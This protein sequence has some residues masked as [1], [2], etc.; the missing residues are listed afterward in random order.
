MGLGHNHIGCPVVSVTNVMVRA[1]AKDRSSGPVAPEGA[2]FPANSRG[3]GSSGE[4]FRAIGAGPANELDHGWGL[5]PGR[6]LR[7]GRRRV[8]AA[9]ARTNDGGPGTA[10]ERGEAP[11]SAFVA[12]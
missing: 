2:Q 8:Q 5:R 12:A 9:A 6:V 7:F 11:T 1:G 4:G 10:D 3:R